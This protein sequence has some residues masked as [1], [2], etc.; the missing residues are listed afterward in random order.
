PHPG[1][2]GDAR[3]G[4]ELGLEPVQRRP[5]A[6]CGGLPTP[7][8]PAP[9]LEQYFESFVGLLRIGGHGHAVHDGRLGT[10]G[11]GARPPQ[12]DAGATTRTPVAGAT[13]GRLVAG[14][15]ARAPV[16][17]GNRKLPEKKEGRSRPD[18]APITGPTVP[19]RWSKTET[20]PNQH[21]APAWPV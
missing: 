9:I 13:N 18:L 3:G 15:T 2:A 8:T 16:G 6:H 10:R 21:V 14:A 7:P 20:F 17:G 4:P 12:A 19:K 1:A 5:T 11:P